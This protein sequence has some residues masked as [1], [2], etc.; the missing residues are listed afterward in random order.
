V[1]FLRGPLS[2]V[3]KRIL[4]EDL[5]RGQSPYK[6]SATRA[7]RAMGVS[8]ACGPYLRSCHSPYKQSADP[9]AR[10]ATGERPGL[11]PL[12]AQLS[13]LHTSGMRPGRERCHGR[14]RGV[15]PLFARG[16][17]SGARAP[18]GAC[19][20]C[21]PYFARRPSSE[22]G[23][24]GSGAPS[25]TCCSSFLAQVGLDLL[26]HLALIFTCTPPAQCAFRTS[27]HSRPVHVSDQRA[28]SGPVSHSRTRARLGSEHIL[29]QCGQLRTSAHLAPV[30]HLGPI[31]GNQG[32]LS[33]QA[34][35]QDILEASALAALTF[36]M[37]LSPLFPFTSVKVK[38]DHVP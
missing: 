5:A 38:V 30:T 12:L 15:R 10:R 33:H 11:R 8:P 18:G 31:P 21:G 6:Q 20:A 25:L 28:H 26:H 9:R 3:G 14:P 37:Y 35:F 24:A 16:H 2:A 27:A 29:D 32:H 13:L 7:R 34:T 17:W 22:H 23:A 4:F 36:W 19:P 1:T